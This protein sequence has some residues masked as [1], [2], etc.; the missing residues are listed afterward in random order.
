MDK[1]P[2]RKDPGLENG[3]YGKNN[4]I[5]CHKMLAACKH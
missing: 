1:I 5:K 2:V 4:I 3:L